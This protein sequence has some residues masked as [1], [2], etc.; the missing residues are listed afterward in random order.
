[1]VVMM[2]FHVDPS[3]QDVTSATFGGAAMT[4]IHEIT[5][6]NTSVEMWGILDADLPAGE[7]VRVTVD[8]TPVLLYRDGQGIYAINAVC[9]HAGGPLDEGAVEG[10]CV[11]CPWHASVFD[12]RDGSIVH[13][14]TA[15]PQAAYETRIQ[16]GQIALRARQT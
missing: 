13:G 8:D 11:T 5:G 3:P 7:P 15:F 14:P 2:I 6:V 16:D 4:Q 12:L 9:A 10:V 1:M